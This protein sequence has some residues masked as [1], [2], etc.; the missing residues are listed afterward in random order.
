[1]TDHSLVVTDAMTEAALRVWYGEE[2]WLVRKHGKFLPFVEQ[3]ARMTEAIYAALAV[4]DDDRAVLI[5][6]GDP[7]REGD[8]PP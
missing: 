7:G 4:A 3:D 6:T 1:M 8:A 5:K 2:I